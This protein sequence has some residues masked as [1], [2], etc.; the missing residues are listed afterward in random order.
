MSEQ[1]LSDLEVRLKLAVE[2][3][4]KDLGT[5]RTGRAKPSLVEEVKVEA[6]GSI[7]QVKE[8]ASISAPDTTLIVISPWDKSLI[9]SIAN[10]I[11]KAELNLNPI[12]DGEVV[13]IAVPALNEER[14][15]ELVKMVGQKIESGRV[16][17][18]QVRVEIKEE[19]EAEEGEG[20]VSE[21]DIKRWL[22][23]MQRLVDKYGEELTE[24]GKEKEKEL[25]TI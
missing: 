10:G 1:I 15:L 6:Y 9:G 12:V 17:L 5:I 22:T 4:K 11:R 20:G 16:M 21:D 24:L 3:V 23:E 2:A 19:I 8:L 7:M 25:M 14:R 18:R 13:K